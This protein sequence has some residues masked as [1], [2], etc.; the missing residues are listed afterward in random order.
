ML[1]PLYCFLFIL[2]FQLQSTPWQEKLNQ[3]H[4]YFLKKNIDVGI[5]FLFKKKATTI[6]PLKNSFFNIKNP[7]S[8][9]FDEKKSLIKDSATMMT[10]EYLNETPWEKRKKP[11]LNTIE[12]LVPLYNFV[13][14]N[15][16]NK[17]GQYF[18]LDEYLKL[19][20]EGIIKKSMEDTIKGYQSICEYDDDPSID[21]L[22]AY[23][24]TIKLPNPQSTKM[25]LLTF[26]D[27]GYRNPLGRF[28][29]TLN[30]TRQKLLRYVEF[31]NFNIPINM[32]M[33]GALAL[34]PFFL[35][36]RNFKDWAY[37]YGLVGLQLPDFLSIIP[38]T[39]ALYL[40]IFFCGGLLLESS[41]MGSI[42]ILT[43][44]VFCFGFREFGYLRF[45]FMNDLHHAFKLSIK[46]LKAFMK[47]YFG[48]FKHT[49]DPGR[50]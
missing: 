29:L 40:K 46:L 7:K 17:I 49:L 48:F 22:F 32:M 42:K 1:K 14:G 18:S 35:L 43:G 12:F 4:N 33:S 10:L 21:P 36:N 13:H 37:S 6:N 26:V 31:L 41:E 8:L 45:E 23:F 34:D 27:E 2:S 30:L 24:S 25:P 28:Y 3:W 15:I 16:L 20:K 50:S 38:S 9:D 44:T 19:E 39:G 5:G 47:H 11:S